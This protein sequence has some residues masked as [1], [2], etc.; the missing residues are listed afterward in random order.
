MAGA[1]VASLGDTIDGEGKVKPRN[2]ALDFAGT[3]AKKD[4][5]QSAAEK[6]VSLGGRVT[7]T[8]FG[9]LD[10]NRLGDAREPV[11]RDG[12]NG[13]GPRKCQ[14]VQAAA[15]AREHDTRR[16]NASHARQPSLI[17]SSGEEL[18]DDCIEG[19]GQQAGAVRAQGGGKPPRSPVGKS[20]MN[21]AAKEDSWQARIAEELDGKEE[22]TEPM[23]EGVHYET[24]RSPKDQGG[25]QEV[26]S[27]ERRIQTVA[28]WERAVNEVLGEETSGGESG[29]K[30]KKRLSNE[31]AEGDG[32][33]ADKK[34]LRLSLDGKN[35]HTQKL[36]DLQNLS[37]NHEWPQNALVQGKESGALETKDCELEDDAFPTDA[38][39][40]ANQKLLFHPGVAPVR[41][42]PAR[43]SGFK[44]QGEALAVYP[45]IRPSRAALS[46]GAEGGPELEWV[47]QLDEST[48]EAKAP[49][50]TEAYKRN[51]RMM[52]ARGFTR[53]FGP[54]TTQVRKGECG[55]SPVSIRLLI[56]LVSDLLHDLK[57]RISAF[58]LSIPM[59]AL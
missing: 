13:N 38:L 55:H 9:E 3:V 43:V 48:V 14:S 29:R 7:R 21:R 23:L 49:E 31:T 15:V 45:K 36:A 41:S 54:A 11:H 33:G 22:R 58:W 6:G 28:K 42:P 18:Q 47:R 12:V 25:G 19:G 4:T 37:R 26:P 34:R 51:K 27:A 20:K 1:V 30:G 2:L 44:A 35:A 24:L 17:L 52:K 16:R 8:C 53:V 50:G 40:L 32:S 59:G 5:R 46:Q 57:G 39:V 10:A 56:Y